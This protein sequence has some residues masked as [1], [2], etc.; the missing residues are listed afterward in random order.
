MNYYK[1]LMNEEEVT[2]ENSSKFAYFEINAK[3]KNIKK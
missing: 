1:L 2:E 3:I